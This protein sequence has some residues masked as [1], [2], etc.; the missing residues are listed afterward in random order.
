[1]EYTVGTAGNQP[2]GR[3]SSTTLAHGI[4]NKLTGIDGRVI[5]REGF[6]ATAQSIGN[7]LAVAQIHQNRLDGLDGQK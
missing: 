3:S 1:V 7:L 5:V 4:D 6:Q 2:A